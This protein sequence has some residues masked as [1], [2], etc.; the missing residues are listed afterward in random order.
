M[1]AEGQGRKQQVGRQE[2]KAER[3]Y[4][5]LKQEADVNWKWHGTKLSKA[6][7]NGILLPTRLYL[8]KVP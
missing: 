5:N 1:V 4:L 8:L 2:E 6:T 3:P 7:P